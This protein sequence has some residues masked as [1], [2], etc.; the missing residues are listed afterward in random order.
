[1]A[2][3]SKPMDAMVLMM[4]E[5]HGQYI[6][7]YVV[8]DLTDQ[9]QG[10]SEDD[11][12]ILM[13]GP[14]DEAYWEAWDSVLNS[15]YFMDGEYKY[16]LHQDGDCW[17]ICP[18]RMTNE[19]YSNF[20]GEMKPSPDNAYEYEVCEDCVQALVNDDY[21]GMDDAQ[22]VATDEGL[23]LLH[24]E[25]Q[26]VEYDGAEYGFRNNRCECCDGLPGERFR[27]LCFNKKGE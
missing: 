16:T 13:N 7:Q 3:M 25:Y 18:E 1:M 26:R 8:A 27:V 9:W 14:D 6:P 12:T 22:Q 20:F 24:K 10:I 21:S 19:E 17:A 4:D 23:T 5:R 15:A 11:R 2:D